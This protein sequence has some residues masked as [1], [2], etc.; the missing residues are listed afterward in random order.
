MREDRYKLDILGQQVK[1]VIILTAVRHIT[2]HE[3]CIIDKL[4]NN[5]VSEIFLIHQG[6]DISQFW[7]SPICKILY[8]LNEED[9]SYLNEVLN[10]CL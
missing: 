8:C 7:R 1:D 3:Y 9:K 2:Y 5:P 10:Y 6:T 4:T